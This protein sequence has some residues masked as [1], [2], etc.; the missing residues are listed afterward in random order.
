MGWDVVRMAESGLPRTACLR[1]QYRII[2]WTFVSSIVL[3]QHT[4]FFL[5]TLGKHSTPSGALSQICSP[6]C[7]SSTRKVCTGSKSIEQS[8][9][10]TPSH[11]GELLVSV[12]S[13]M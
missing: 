2:K 13:A 3:L 9:N 4:P 7:C 11:L 5:R 8:T 12:T 6:G 10:I 1:H